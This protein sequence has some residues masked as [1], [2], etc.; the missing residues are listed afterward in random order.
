M[1]GIKNHESIEIIDIL[2]YIQPALAYNLRVRACPDRTIQM[3][4]QRSLIDDS[5]YSVFI[6]TT[7]IQW[8][9]VF[10]DM[11]IAK[12]CLRL[13]EYYRNELNLSI[14]AYALLPNHLHAIIKSSSKGDISVFMRKWKSLS[15]KSI[16]DLC[17]IKHEKWLDEFRN[18]AVKY[19][20][21]GQFYQVWMPRYDDFAIRNE[22]ELLIKLNYIHSNPLKHNLV[23]EA[24]DYPF[25]S[26]K[27]Y[28]G[29]QNGFVK[30][31]GGQG[32]P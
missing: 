7:I 29:E 12:E 13:F 9:P 32:K 26:L 5:I 11:D 24:M 16:I 1:G 3:K 22:R 2:R 21:T 28:M 27:D 23:E 25:S 18:N 10:K 20:I 30:I 31:D 6:T 8:I 14:F 19:K 15:A 4:R 17:Q